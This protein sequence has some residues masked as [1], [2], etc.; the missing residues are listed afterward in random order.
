MNISSGS[1]IRDPQFTCLHIDMM[2]TDCRTCDI[3]QHIPRDAQYVLAQAT[4]YNQRRHARHSVRHT[5]GVQCW[6]YTYTGEHRDTGV[7]KIDTRHE[8]HAHLQVHPSS[9][10]RDLGAR[11]LMTRS[12]VYFARL[13]TPARIGS[14]T[15]RN[16][17]GADT[18][19][20]TRE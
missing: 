9:S 5:H 6:V 2:T 15:E 12:G 20:G 4:R 19:K 17:R 8:S 13:C 3:H 10:R 16:R 18:K 11:R 1:G 7:C 14:K